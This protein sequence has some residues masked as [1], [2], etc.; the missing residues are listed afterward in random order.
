MLYHLF[1]SSIKDRVLG[2]LY[3]VSP[4]FKDI[5]GI[6]KLFSHVLRLSDDNFLSGRTIQLGGRHQDCE[7]TNFYFTVSG[8]KKLSSI[9][10]LCTP[11][12][13][14]SDVSQ[15][16]YWLSETWVNLAMGKL[17]EETH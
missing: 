14:Q 17:R 4:T 12:K 16:E 8:R 1:H 6:V 7:R 13:T 9:F 11:L 15:V 5:K 3:K 2:C 10:K